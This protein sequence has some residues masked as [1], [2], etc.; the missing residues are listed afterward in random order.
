MLKRLLAR[1]AYRYLREELAALS[2]ERRLLVLLEQQGPQLQ[3][4]LASVV[5]RKAGR[6]L[7]G[8]PGG[9]ARH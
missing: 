4:L 8:R 6:S 2:P 3:A 9:I 1:L 7:P 5:G